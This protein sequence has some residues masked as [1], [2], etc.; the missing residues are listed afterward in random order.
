MTHSR[1]CACS[2]A[3]ASI[4]GVIKSKS[5]IIRFRHRCG[6]I[7]ERHGPQGNELTG[8]DA[9]IRS[10]G[11]TDSGRGHSIPMGGMAF[12]PVGLYA[13]MMYW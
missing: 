3:I 9:V 12:R 1:P 11:K 10:P 8:A 7:I 5:A 4:D 13:A 2:F 6:P